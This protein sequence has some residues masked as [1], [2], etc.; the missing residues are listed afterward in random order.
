MSAAAE[1]EL[2]TGRRQDRRFILGVLSTGHGVTHWFDQSF[3]ILLPTI[4]ASLGLS[5][6]QVGSVA[7]VR[8]VAFGLINLPGGL[9]VDTLKRR[10]GLILTGCL[11]WAGVFY[12]L[13]GAS[14]NYAF[15][16]LM[17][18]LASF[19]GPLWHLPAAAALSQRFPE[20]RGFAISVHGAGANLGNVLGPLLAGALLVVITWREILFMYAAPAVLMALVVWL[21]LQNIGRDSGPEERRGFKSQME[22]AAALLRNRIIIGLV[23]V[24]LL[25]G[26]ALN[27]LLIWTPFYLQDELGM[28][29]LKTGMYMA[30]VMGTGIVSTPILGALSDRYN[31]KYVMVP[32]LAL[33]ALLAALVVSAGAGVWL[34][35]VLAATGLFSFALHQIIQAAVLDIVSRGTEA[36]ATGFLFGAN[37]IMGAFSPLIAVAII[38][39]FGL[40]NVFYYQAGLTAA[41]MLLLLFI[42]LG[43]RPAPGKTTTA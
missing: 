15:F 7:T 32:G 14:F 18:F 40:E 6:L 3:P 37:G 2:A 13:M 25:R 42:P 11:V 17:V 43:R 41:A 26:M 27:A 29:T 36:T 38:N 34:I 30:L 31:R 35:V 16:V 28:G 5:T 12:A 10:W 8:E 9:V 24:A 22:A 21:F 23:G 33:A 19:P 20:W 1:A 4:A 39:G